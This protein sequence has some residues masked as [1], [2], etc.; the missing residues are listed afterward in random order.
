ML[1][2]CQSLA[3]ELEMEKMDDN[4][5]ILVDRTNRNIDG[6]RGISTYQR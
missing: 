5:M 1:I 4:M 6:K 3:T 2:F